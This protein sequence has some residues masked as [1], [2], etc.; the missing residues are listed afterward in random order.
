MRYLKYFE[1]SLVD[2][3]IKLLD[4]IF[5]DLYDENFDYN[6]INGRGTHMNLTL[7]SNTNLDWSFYPQST[8]I[9]I[10]SK[11]SR[12]PSNYIY[13]VVTKEVREFSDS[14]KKILEDFE[15]KIRGLGMSPRGGYGGHNFRIFYFDKWGKMT[16]SNLLYL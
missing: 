2:R 5:L 7:F 4:Q 16:D 11:S 9:G 12:P 8:S 6:V 3:K 13:V 1:S 10:V 15:T 14:D